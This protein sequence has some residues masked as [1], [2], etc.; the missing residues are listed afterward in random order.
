MAK[1]R[2]CYSFYCNLLSI[3]KDGLVKKVSIYGSHTSILAVFL[4][5]TLV[6]AQTFTLGY[7]FTL[8]ISSTN[9]L[10]QYAM[11]MYMAIIKLL[12]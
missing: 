1:T 3:G 12:K 10:C 2:T 5:Q 6:L 7:I 4:T 8:T 9:K 11:K